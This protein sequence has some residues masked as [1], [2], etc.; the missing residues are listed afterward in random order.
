VSLT[1]R[2]DRVPLDAAALRRELVRPGG[3]WR[4]VQVVVET[5]STNTDLMQAARDGAPEG[6]VLAA[7]VQTAGRGRLDR[8]WVSP[9]RAGLHVSVLL[10]PAGVPP[11]CRGWLPLLTGV[12]VAT[13]LRDGAGLDAVLK[14]PNDVLLGGAKVAGILAEQSGDAIVVGFGINVSH[15]R[16]ELPVP[17]ATSVALAGGPAGRGP[18]LAAVLGE[19]AGWY[20]RWRAAPGGSADACGLRPAYLRLS[21]TVGQQVSVHLPGG[22]L[23]AGRASGVDEAGRL[24]VDGPDGP[25]AVS[26]GDV[27]HLR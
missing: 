10:R 3:L 22:Q 9:P 13:A 4:D 26:A 6:I 24:L 2:T 21:A 18:L 17:T 19:L 7:E 11:A 16:D 15:Q 1:A 8:A 12:A 23:L 20:E 27:V 25:T 5:G 14:W